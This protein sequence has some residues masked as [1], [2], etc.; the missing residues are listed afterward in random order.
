MDNM[1][2]RND[3]TLIYNEIN[4]IYNRYILQLPINL[5]NILYS[6][7]KQIDGDAIYYDNDLYCRLG[8]NFTSINGQSL[9]FN[10]KEEILNLYF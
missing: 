2:L 7:S 9:I 8:S 1:I 5:V 10:S 6:I 3:G 4:N